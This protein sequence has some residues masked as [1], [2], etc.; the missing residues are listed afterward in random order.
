MKKHY[1]I[2][3]LCLSLAVCAQALA[4]GAHAKHG[5]ILQ[6]V[7]D[8]DF[9]L[10]NGA[11]RASLYISDHGQ[12][13]STAGAGGKLTILNGSEKT[14]LLLAPGPDQTLVTPGKAPLHK[15]AKAIASILFADQRTLNVRFS[16]K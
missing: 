1:A 7:D 8:V 10:V 3:G 5:G 15:G 9:E 13:V 2:L 12:P 14:E 11:E 4:H 16:V 6:S